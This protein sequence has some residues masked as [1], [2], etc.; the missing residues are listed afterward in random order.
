MVLNEYLENNKEKLTLRD[1]NFISELVYGVV[2]WKLTLDTIIEKY[3]KTKLKKISKWVLL[4]LELGAYQIVFLDKVPKSAAV[5]ESVNLCKKY[6][7]QSANF[8]NAILR[9]VEKIDYKK[10]EEITD[11][12]IKISKMYSM[13]EWIIKIFIDDYG[14][15]KTE[16]ICKNLNLKPK[17]TI[18]IN[19]LKINE[20]DFLKKLEERNISYEKS[21]APNFIYL[22][23]LNDISK[24][25][26]FKEGY[27]IVQ[28]EG[29]GKIVEML[30]PKENEIVLDA[31]SA[32]GGKTT[33]LAE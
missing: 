25:D 11:P 2:T 27:F 9:K 8:V 32:P 14:I 4:I 18:R 10:L 20:Q 15:Q 21:D 16:D 29:A 22:K 19:S 31:C 33:Y 17:L 3:S 24:L 26:L 12:S 7:F 1:K 13:P 6:G 28:D 5:N 30:N 23:G